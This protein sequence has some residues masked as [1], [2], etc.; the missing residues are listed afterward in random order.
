VWRTND[1]DILTE[2]A[3]AGLVR[4]GPIRAQETSKF[5]GTSPLM[6]FAE[7]M[8]FLNCRAWDVNFLYSHS[9]EIRLLPRKI[10]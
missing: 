1:S 5:N 7:V 10:P 6:L 2:H 9:G 4:D 3:D 8:V